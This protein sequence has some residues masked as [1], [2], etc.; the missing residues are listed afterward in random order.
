[1]PADRFDGHSS[2]GENFA[3]SRN[4]EACCYLLVGSRW[5]LLIP[6]RLR[7]V[8]NISQWALDGSR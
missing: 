1:M 4:P 5:L 8:P 6:G 3:T 2:E 7:M